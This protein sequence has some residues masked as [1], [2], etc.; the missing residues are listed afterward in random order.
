MTQKKIRDYVK[1]LLPKRLF[2]AIEP[3]GHLV[4]AMLLSTTAGSPAKKMHVIGVTGTN[5]KTTTSFMIHSILVE[6]GLKAALQTTVGNGVGRD[7]EPQIHHMTSVS[8]GLLQNRLK[9][10]VEAGAEWLVMETTSHALAQHRDFGLPYEI[11]VLTNI[12]HEHLDYHKTFERYRSAKLLLFKRAAKYGMKLGVINADDPSAEIFKAAVPNSMMYGLQHG[13]IRPEHLD[14]QADKSTYDVTIEET[15]YHITCHIPGEYNVSNSLAAVCVG[16]RLGLPKE[17]IERGIANLAS[18]EGR[19]NTIRLGQAYT[20]IVDYAHTPDAFERLFK[21]LRKA[22]KG[23]LVAV[24]GSAGRRDESKRTEQGKIAGNYADELIL[25]EEDD[26][27]ID[28]NEILEQIAAGA[29]SSGKKDDENLFKILDRTEAIQFAITRVSGP[30]DTVVFLGKGHEKTIERADGEHPWDET[31]VVKDA[32]NR[33]L[34][35]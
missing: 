20:A 14:M 27:D 6:A 17:A 5:G 18:V 25:T 2:E 22:T 12:T 23:K 19:M 9:K 34:E 8:P 31:E 32:I 11:A 16:H 26:R 33:E 30:E 7:I 28:G 21:D 24:F 10:F 15:T 3:T 29:R 13:D 1:P 35:G 4:E